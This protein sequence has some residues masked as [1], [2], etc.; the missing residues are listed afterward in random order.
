M[1]SVCEILQLNYQRHP[2]PPILLHL[3]TDI[4]TTTYADHRY[5]S[6]ALVA[7]W[8]WDSLPAVDWCT[9]DSKAKLLAPF[10]MS[11]IVGKRLTFLWGGQSALGYHMEFGHRRS[12]CLSLHCAFVFDTLSHQTWVKRI[13]FHLLLCFSCCWHSPHWFSWERLNISWFIFNWIS[14]RQLR[15]ALVMRF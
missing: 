12:L 9:I 8:N 13:V 3:T 7:K 1:A 11:F 15:L 14:S 5:S 10:Q 4:V 6:V 2:P